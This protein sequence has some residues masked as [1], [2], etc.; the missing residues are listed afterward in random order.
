VVK[1]LSR[2]LFFW[3]KYFDYYLLDKPGAR[4]GAS[5]LYFIGTRSDQILSDR[6]LVERYGGLE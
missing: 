1:G 6:E 2:V 3:V 4:K 5:S